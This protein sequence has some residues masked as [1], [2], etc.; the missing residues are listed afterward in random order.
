[1]PMVRG[2]KFHWM[3]AR[4]TSITSGNAVSVKNN[5]QA[6]LNGGGNKVVLSDNDNIYQSMAAV[7]HLNFNGAGSSASLQG[8]WSNIT[9]NGSGNTFTANG[10]QRQYPDERKWQQCQR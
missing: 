6:W 2:M 4:T 1:M 10:K 7:I 8:D 9:L 5:T 3:A